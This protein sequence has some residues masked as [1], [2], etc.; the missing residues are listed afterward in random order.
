M[1]IV[2]NS[3]VRRSAVNIANTSF[4]V[5]GLIH[6]RLLLLFNVKKI[7]VKHILKYYNIIII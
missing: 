4:G 5:Q 7:N 6:N 3:L 2:N 1:L